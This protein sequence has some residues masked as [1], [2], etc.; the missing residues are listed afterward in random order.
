MKNKSKGFTY[1]EC[2][3]SLS[4]IILA[5]SLIYTSLYGSYTITNKNVEYNMMLNEAKNTLECTKDIV[6]SSDEDLISDFYKE[7][8]KDDVKIQMKLEKVN[9][10]YRCYKVDVKVSNDRTDIE[11]CSFVTQQ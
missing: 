4:I 11:L 2:I 5:V 3:M 8:K 6:L 7:V 10:Y 1:I 9:N